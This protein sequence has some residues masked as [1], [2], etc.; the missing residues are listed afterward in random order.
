MTE[1]KYSR[2]KLIW[3]KQESIVKKQYFFSLSVDTLK[4][5]LVYIFTVFSSV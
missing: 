2:S 4:I 1:K 5:K 3:K